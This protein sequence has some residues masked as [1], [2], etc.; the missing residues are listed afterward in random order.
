MKQ[1]DR[2]AIVSARL[3]ALRQKL[4]EA[5]IDGLVIT[6]WANAYYLTLFECSN[7]LLVVSRDRSLFL[8]DSRYTEAAEQSLGSPWELLALRAP[9][10]S[11]EL[12]CVLRAFQGKRIGFEENAPYSHYRRLKKCAP[13]G[14]EI[15]E[16]G[17]LITDLR[18]VKDS[19]E[20]HLIA[21]SQ[22]INESILSSVLEEISH[23]RNATT[24]ELDLQRRIRTRMA[25]RGV[26]EAFPTI[27]AFG[28]SSS[29]PHARPS[30]NPLEDSS[31]VL[32]DMGV[33]YNQYCSD[34]TR[35]FLGPALTTSEKIREIYD[36]VLEAQ[37]AAL[38]TVKDGIPAKEV[39]RR[40][41]EVI[42]RAGYGEFFGHGLGHGVGLEIHEAPTLNP[43]SEDVLKS[44]MVITIE[45]GIY[46]PGVGGVRIEDLVVVTDKGHT[47]LTRYP[48]KWQSIFEGC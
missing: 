42:Q 1:P 48:K 2:S 29:R 35:T 33:K 40:A 4:Y 30:S 26:E 8:T 45:P 3:T 17:K 44:G 22:T 20:L 31:V 5:Q 15:V 21:T 9:T 12:T 28:A 27:V 18:S 39:D 36:I 11:E 34:M 41:R 16:A 14:S 10:G 6:T 25:E 13:N 38:E 43:N 7:P 46:L 23:S 32:V 37:A 19:Y 47:N 24:S